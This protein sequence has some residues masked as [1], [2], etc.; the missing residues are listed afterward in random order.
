MIA[1]GSSKL[2][3]VSSGGGGA[4]AP[5]AGAAAGGAAAAEE[6]AEE[7]VEG[8]LRE[9]HVPEINANSLNR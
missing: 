9:S 7:K 1:E 5:A 6:K 2:A 4:A 8:T 3:S